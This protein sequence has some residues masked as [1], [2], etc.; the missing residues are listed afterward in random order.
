M[1]GRS[2][3]LHGTPV[4]GVYG[5]SRSLVSSLFKNKLE[6]VFPNQKYKH[7]WDI[8][9]NTKSLSNSLLSNGYSYNLPLV[10]VVKDLQK[11]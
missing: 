7:K 2:G 3:M 9:T 8:G 5:S 10:S 6:V 4:Y 1:R 11:Y